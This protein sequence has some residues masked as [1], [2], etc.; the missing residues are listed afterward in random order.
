M[1]D[2]MCLV[3]LGVRAS[4]CKQKIRKG[5]MFQQDSYIVSWEKIKKKHDLREEIQI[6]IVS[7][8]FAIHDTSL[9]DHVSFYA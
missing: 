5:N 3:S 9:N 1:T 2:T 7:Q 4:K 6:E 8:F